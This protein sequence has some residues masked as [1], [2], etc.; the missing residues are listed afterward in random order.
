MESVGVRTFNHAFVSVPY[1]RYMVSM[2]PR[3]IMHALLEGTLKVEGHALL[4]CAIHKYKWFSLASLNAAIKAHNW[5]GKQSV[6]P[7]YSST[8]KGAV[9]GKPSHK[10]SL[11]FT[12]G[13]MLSF[14]LH[15]TELM[16]PLMSPE[17]LERAEWKSW[18]M[19]VR[20]LAS[21]LTRSYTEET[22]A[23][24]DR[25]IFDHHSAYLAIPHYGHL[26]KPKF[27]FVQHIPQDIRNW[28][29]PRDV[30]CMRTEA[31][32][33]EMK[34][35]AKKGNFR[36]VCR[37]VAYFWV[38]RTAYRMR[39]RLHL[40]SNDEMVPVGSEPISVAERSHIIFRQQFPDAVHIFYYSEVMRGGIRYAPGTWVIYRLPGAG[41]ARRLALVSSIVCL[42]TESAQ[43]HWL[44][45]ARPNGA[46]PKP[47]DDGVPCL[48]IDAVDAP[49]ASPAMLLLDVWHFAPLFSFYYD[50]MVRFV[51]Q[52]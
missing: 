51:E 16:R 11:S 13:E 12:A 20:I 18:V 15:S 2:T 36:D 28:G 34:K 50:G 17:G 23:A 30:W 41:G 39:H 8:I 4:Y 33:Q 49:T 37:D 25:L 43:E 10:G 40:Y 22:I 1:F 29:A 46:T 52:H 42:T 19:H 47:G 32:N 3:D 24:L 27:H 5:Q 7:I 38:Q 21:C 31:K 14:V 48:S 44:L 9:G 6:P 26:F 35:A 45:M